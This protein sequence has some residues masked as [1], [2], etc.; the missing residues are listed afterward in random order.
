MSDMEVERN[1]LGA[2]LA[3]YPHFGELQT[4]VYPTDFIDPQHELIWAAA[5]S[6]DEKGGKIGAATVRIAMGKDAL[7]LPGG[8]TYLTDLMHD[9]QIVTAARAYA[10]EVAAFAQRRKLVSTGSQLQALADSGL[11]IAEIADKARAAVDEATAERRAGELVRIGDVMPSVMDIAQNGRVRGLNSGW[12][13]L[14]RLIQGL[15]P[16]RLIVVGARPG[17]G[18]SLMGTNLALQIAGK[19]QRGVL[20]ASMEMGR[21]EVTQRITSAHAAVNL[22]N[23]ENGTVSDAAWNTLAVKAQEV[24]NMPIAIEDGAQQT[25]T[26][27]R[28]DLRKLKRQRAD[29]AL[30]VVDYL[31]LMQPRDRKINRAEQI[32]EISRGLKVMAREFDVCVVAMAQVNREST[33]RADG[34]PTMADLRESGS[35]EADADV[36]V[37]LHRPDEESN[38]IEMHVDKNRSGPRGSGQLELHGHYARLVEAHWSPTQGIA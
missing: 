22:T 29:T 11:D 31:Q 5:A 18:K 25:V 27:I 23:L 7:K 3:G 21:D 28:N 30:V 38:R 37:L 8:P 4:I 14:D 26:S 15:Q 33:R 19:H 17:V 24:V 12:D 32:G 36:V 10:Q 20:I 1:L 16:G 9:C 35:I 2:V 6:V 13:N 34:R